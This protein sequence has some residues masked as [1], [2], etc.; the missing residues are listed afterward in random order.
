M[1][2]VRRFSA[3]CLV[4]ASNLDSIAEIPHLEM[5]ALGIFEL[6]DLSVLESV[7]PN[8]ISL[9]LT[10]TR[11]K[12]PDLA[13]IRRFPGLRELFIE[14]HTKNIGVISELRELE[15]LTLR[16][17]TTPDVSYLSP[18]RNLWSLDI[19]LGGIK[20]FDGLRGMSNIKYLELWQ[21]M[22]L[23]D[24]SFISDLRGLQN[25]FLE[26]ITRLKAIPSLRDSVCLRRVTVST[27]KSLQD[28]SEL[29]WA[30]AL[31]EFG[32]GGNS[33]EPEQLLPVLRNPN[34]RRIAAGFGS[35]RKNRQFDD[36]R[37]EF[38]RDEFDWSSPFEYL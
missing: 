9:G 25:L 24:V 33:Q 16:S 20:S 15:D 35:D 18:L 30:P 6:R 27:M 21:V 13:V 32:L 37:R 36:L 3:D 4:E 31:Q 8:L 26:A 22:G 14:G 5:L 19:K 7:S 17:I 38:R 11:S 28:F 34:V 1:T 12:K 29:E 2:N 23:E 10:A